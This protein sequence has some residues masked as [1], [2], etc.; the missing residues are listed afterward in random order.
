MASAAFNVASIFTGLPEG[1]TVSLPAV[2]NTL[3]AS[4]FLIGTA[5]TASQTA[6]AAL[7]YSSGVNLTITSGTTSILGTA[8]QT[9][10]FIGSGSSSTSASPNPILQYVSG[11]LDLTSST[12]GAS[13]PIAG[14]SIGRYY[15]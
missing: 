14:T 15:G 10:Y 8:G 6:R 7:T 13:S 11:D 12:N 1:A 5:T 2:A 9:Y 4:S 3:A